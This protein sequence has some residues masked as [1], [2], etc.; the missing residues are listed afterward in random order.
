METN[1]SSPTELEAI[2]AT[3]EIKCVKYRIKRSKLAF[4]HQVSDFQKSSY[5][6]I[7][8]IRRRHNSNFKHFNEI[9]S[10]QNKKI[11]SMF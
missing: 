2:I 9:L 10:V 7:E 5:L 3:S 4:Y 6:L 1:W 11:Y 8:G